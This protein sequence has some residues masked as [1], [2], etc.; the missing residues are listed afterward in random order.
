ML[1]KQYLIEYETKLDAIQHRL[2][3]Y[4]NECYFEDEIPKEL[5]SEYYRLLDIVQRLKNEIKSKSIVINK[6]V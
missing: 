1:E 2:D 6:K 5:I 4:Y 3:F